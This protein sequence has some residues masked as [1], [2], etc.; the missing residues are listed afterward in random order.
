MNSDWRAQLPF[1]ILGTTIMVNVSMSDQNQTDFAVDVGCCLRS[2]FQYSFA[3]APGET[4][5]Q[6]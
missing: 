5:Y 4:I 2:S 6:N 1:Q 3:M